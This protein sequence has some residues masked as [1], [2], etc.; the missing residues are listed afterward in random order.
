MIMR[1]TITSD[2]VQNAVNF[3]FKTRTGWPL[4]PVDKIQ[5]ALRFS[6]LLKEYES[7]LSF[8]AD[9]EVMVI[10]FDTNIKPK[11]IRRIKDNLMLWLAK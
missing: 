2:A 5:T 6:G 3:F 7:L 4:Y 8:D 1:R 11:L 10:S 9:N